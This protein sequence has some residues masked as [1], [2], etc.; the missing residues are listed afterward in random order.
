MWRDNGANPLRW[1]CTKQGCFNQ[2]KRPKIELFADCLPGRIAFTDIDAITE[3]NG[4]L[5]VLEWKDHTELPKG[6]RIL[7]ERLTLGCPATVLVIEGDAEQM[8]VVSIRMVWRGVIWP[9]EP[10]D[11][12]RL[13]REIQAWAR[14]AA[15]TPALSRTPRA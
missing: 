6:Q 8:S 3:I 13:R 9:P 7:F 12:D 1:D 10:A 5:L 15:V 2:K 4:H 14:W 11:L